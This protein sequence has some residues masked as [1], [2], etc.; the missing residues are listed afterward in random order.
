MKLHL[1]NYTIEEIAEIKCCSIATARRHA[2]KWGG[3]KDSD[4]RRWLFPPATVQKMLYPEEVAVA[5]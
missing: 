3:K 1:R 4:S 2:E 5:R